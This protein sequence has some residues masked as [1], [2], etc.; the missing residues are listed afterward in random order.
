MAGTGLKDRLAGARASWHSRRSGVVALVGFGRRGA[1]TGVQAV[2]DAAVRVD[3]VAPSPQLDWADVVDGDVFLFD[4]V[5]RLE[6][7]H[8]DPQ[9]ADGGP[10]KATRS[11]HA[12]EIPGCESRE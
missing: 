1:R 12:V 5:G 3:I 4:E 11:V 6:F 10:R 2:E 7:T 9:E 8:H